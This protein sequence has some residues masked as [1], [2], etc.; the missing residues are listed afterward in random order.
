MPNDDMNLRCFA[1][2]VAGLDGTEAC[3]K[4]RRCA[5][6]T[7]KNQ[8]KASINDT[9]EIIKAIIYWLVLVANSWPDKGCTVAKFG[10]IRGLRML[11]REMAL[12]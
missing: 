12:V 4:P 2:T 8:A 6:Q 7:H 10:C 5:A 9:G 1:D 3:L 11:I